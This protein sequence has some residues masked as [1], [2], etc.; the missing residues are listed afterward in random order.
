MNRQNTHNAHRQD[1]MLEICY[2]RLAELIPACTDIDKVVRAINCIARSKKSASQEEAIM[3]DES[4]STEGV[5]NKIVV[6]EQEWQETESSTSVTPMSAEVAEELPI[7]AAD[8]LPDLERWQSQMKSD[9]V[10]CS[11]MRRDRPFAQ[12]VTHC[13]RSLRRLYRLYEKAESNE[14]RTDL[15][16]RVISLCNEIKALR[17]SCDG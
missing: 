6:T 1:A 3:P 13:M 4:V 14:E 8:A 16:E 10:L 5:E 12:R 9:A 11:R 15:G 7:H 17:R 2:N